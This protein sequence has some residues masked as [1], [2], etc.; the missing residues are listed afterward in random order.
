[1]SSMFGE[2]IRAALP[3]TVSVRPLVATTPSFWLCMVMGHSL[4]PLWVVH[5]WQWC[6]MWE[7][8]S[9]VAPQVGTVSEDALPPLPILASARALVAPSAARPQVREGC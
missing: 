1:M 5:H 3:A 9:H 6:C 4:V 7:H 8:A 2:Q